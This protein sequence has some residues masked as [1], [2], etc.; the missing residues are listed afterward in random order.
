MESASHIQPLTPEQSSL[1][2]E[3]RHIAFDV[4]RIFSRGLGYDLK[5]DVRS[6]AM[7]GLIQAAMSFE[8]RDGVTFE[9]YAK[10]RVKGSVRDLLR[11]EA[12]GFAGRSVSDR[13]RELRKEIERMEHSLLRRPTQKEIREKTGHSFEDLA[14]MN[15][16]VLCTRSKV[17][18]LELIG[19]NSPELAD[20]PIDSHA[21]AEYCEYTEAKLREFARSG[22]GLG[23]VADK[24]FFDLCLGGED[25]VS[26][27]S[28]LGLSIP[29]VMVI[30]DWLAEGIQ[31]LE[32]SSFGTADQEDVEASAEVFKDELERALGIR[33]RY[34]RWGKRTRNKH[35]WIDRRP[36]DPDKKANSLDE[37]AEKLGM[38]K[39]NVS[40]IIGAMQKAICQNPHSRKAFIDLYGY[41]P[42]LFQQELGRKNKPSKAS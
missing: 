37:L 34:Q 21:I 16:G 1:V 41:P 11:K 8:E 9:Q 18:S 33:E 12:R 36:I 24:V 42:E 7:M 38:T 10:H 19:K 3:H 31:N 20:R 4:T 39:S 6:E 5:M 28:N 2:E 29:Q 27:S 14:A 23:I 32:F 22:G 13:N 25:M 26:F 40:R 17:K 30:R 15:D 35:M